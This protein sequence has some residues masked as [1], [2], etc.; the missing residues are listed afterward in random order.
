MSCQSREWG[1]LVAKN[2]GYSWEKDVEDDL[3]ALAGQVRSDKLTSRTR[4]QPGSGNKD[5]A[6]GDVVTNLPFLERFGQFVVECK[7]RKDGRGQ[8]KSLS[9][10]KD[11]L[12]KVRCEAQS[13][14]AHPIMAVKIKSPVGG[15]RTPLFP[16][17][18]RNP[19]NTKHVVMPYST[20]LLMLEHIRDLEAEVPKAT[21]KEPVTPAPSLSAECRKC[22][23]ALDKAYESVRHVMGG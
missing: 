15:N 22:R 11:E 20:F 21:S 4:R 14:L 2:L 9:V 5:Y 16:G 3:M 19:M 8:G 10:T 12:D 18:S 6:P 23:K 17:D 13:L 7:H 1:K